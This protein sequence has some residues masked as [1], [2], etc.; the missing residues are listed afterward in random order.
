MDT[1]QAVFAAFMIAAPWLTRT[2]KGSAT[3]VTDK[4]INSFYWYQ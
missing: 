1:V 3:K 2:A 4:L